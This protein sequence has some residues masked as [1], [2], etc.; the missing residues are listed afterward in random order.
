MLPFKSPNRWRE[1]AISLLLLI[2]LT[3]SLIK[4]CYTVSLCYYVQQ[5][6]SLSDGGTMLA[7]NITVQPNMLPQINSQTSKPADVDVIPVVDL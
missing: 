4:V 1:N 2:K 3:F 5:E 7:K 6:F